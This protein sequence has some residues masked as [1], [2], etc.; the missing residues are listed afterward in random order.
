MEA[1]G[2]QKQSEQ[3][4]SV[5][6]EAFMADSLQTCKYHIWIRIWFSAA[7]TQSTYFT[8]PV[9]HFLARE[10]RTNAIRERV[11]FQFL[12]MKDFGEQKLVAIN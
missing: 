6:A 5:N 7:A 3:Q 1:N 12:R 11:K 9:S 10:W 4:G 2:D 8:Q